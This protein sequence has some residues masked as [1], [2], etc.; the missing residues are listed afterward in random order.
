VADIAPANGYA[1]VGWALHQDSVC[2]QARQDAATERLS[3]QPPALQ[4]AIY[5]ATSKTDAGE[6]EDP[7]GLTKYDPS[8]RLSIFC[9]VQLS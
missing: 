9:G 4:I 5:D 8:G 3:T 6:I 2:E 7:S 1:M